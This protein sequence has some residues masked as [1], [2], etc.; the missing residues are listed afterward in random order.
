MDG[1]YDDGNLLQQM[2]VC[3]RPRRKGVARQK[4][5]MGFTADPVAP[6]IG[7]G[8]ATNRNS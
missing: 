1:F 7:S 6:L 8:A 5:A 2:I 3:S 4:I